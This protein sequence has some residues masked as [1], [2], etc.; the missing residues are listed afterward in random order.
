MYFSFYFSIFHHLDG[1]EMVVILCNL[2]SLSKMA[3]F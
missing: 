2:K 3:V 1:K